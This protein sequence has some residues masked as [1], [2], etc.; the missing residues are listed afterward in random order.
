MIRLTLLSL[1]AALIGVGCSHQTK[2]PDAQKPTAAK[3]DAAAKTTDDQAAKTPEPGGNTKVQ[4]SVKG[5]ERT[6]EVRAKDKGCELAYTKAGKEGSV[7]TSAH[8]TEYCE[9]ALEK[10]R[11]KLKGAGYDCK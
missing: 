5:D 9:K 2:K 11:D 6:L 3:S 1:A 8:G 10:L 4:C 7:A